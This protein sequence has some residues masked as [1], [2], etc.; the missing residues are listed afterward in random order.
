MAH[1]HVGGEVEVRLL[2]VARDPAGQL[3]ALVVAL[4]PL[5]S[6]YHHA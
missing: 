2:E 3:V 4:V 6:E 5:I 1:Q